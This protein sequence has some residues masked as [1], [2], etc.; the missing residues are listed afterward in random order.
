MSL[1]ERLHLLWQFMK[2]NAENRGNA[3]LAC[4]KILKIVN[5]AFYIPKDVHDLV[6]SLEEGPTL[7]SQ[8]EI[9]SSTLDELHTKAT[10]QGA[11]LLTHSTLRDAI[12]LGR[13]GKA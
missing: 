1:L 9:L 12:H 8:R 7:R 2:A 4:H 10:L 3:K 11:H 13:F 6:T 5:P